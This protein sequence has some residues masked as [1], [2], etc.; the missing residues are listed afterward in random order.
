MCFLKKEREQISFSQGASPKRNI[1]WSYVIV[2][3]YNLQTDIELSLREA[4]WNSIRMASSHMAA[5][6]MVVFNMCYFIKRAVFVLHL[7]VHWFNKLYIDS[8]RLAM[9][10]YSLSPSPRCSFLCSVS[11]SNFPSYLQRQT[12]A[13]KGWSSLNPRLLSTWQSTLALPLYAAIGPLCR[14]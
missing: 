12:K 10:L 14:F 5:W 9:F 2:L 3:A 11:P 1:H 4:V 13:L 8:K 6:H 7:T